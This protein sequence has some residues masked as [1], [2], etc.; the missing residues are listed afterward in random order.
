MTTRTLAQPGPW[1][2]AGL[3]CVSAWSL[4]A[5]LSPGPAAP[6]PAEWDAAGARIAGEAQPTDVVRIHPPWLR[7]GG[8]AAAG[9]T[10][11]FSLPLDPMA[12]TAFRRLWVL[13]AFERTDAP[14]PP[15][16]ALELEEALAGG[17]L[18]Q[19]FALPPSPVTVRLTEVLPKA[20]VVRDGGRSC[21]Y[22]DGRHACAGKPWE[23]VRLDTRE[24]GG[25]PRSCF[26]VHPYPS[27]K[28]TTITFPALR[29]EAGVLIRSGFVL[30]S[31]KHERGGATTVT[32]RVGGEARGTQVIRPQAWDFEPLYVDTTALRGQA[33]DLV[34]EI[35]S[36]DEAFRDLCIDGF[37]VT[38]P[39]PEAEDARRCKQP[40]ASPTPGRC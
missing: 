37:V 6:S 3:V 2:L 33:A 12:L 40:S 35:S 29:L 24:V 26:L 25:S 10:V 27:G 31:A 16:A 7:E 38:R 5:A 13:T 22:V 4:S 28:V 32:V 34:L 9:L 36:P 23:D 21:R 18:L 8:R 14:A 30:E 39:V 15:G 1:L 19:R 17:L 11:D 20:K